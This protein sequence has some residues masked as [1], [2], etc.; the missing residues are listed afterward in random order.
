[1]EFDNEFGYLG[2]L[3][4]YEY[5]DPYDIVELT[6]MPLADVEEIWNSLNDEEWIAYCKDIAETL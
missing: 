5:W 3:E 4:Y 1:M 2:N 6:N